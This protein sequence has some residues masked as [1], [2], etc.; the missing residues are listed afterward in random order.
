[1]LGIPLPPYRASAVAFLLCGGASALA[2]G[3]RPSP[4]DQPLRFFEGRTE[5]VSTVKVVMKKPYQSRTIGN[6]RILPD[7][8]LALV[9]EVRE[10]GKPLV[11]RHWKIR[12]VGR[13]KFAGTMSDAV[14]PVTVNEAKGTYRFQFKLKGH[15]AVDQW[16]RPLP[17]GKTAQ[18]RMTVRKL[19]MQ[20]ASSQGIIRKI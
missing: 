6:G 1:M 14:G 5:M 8:S 19:G 17:G 2:S 16:V 18:S 4:A 15:L 10:E 11:K 7:G 12:E 9:Q 20:V 13:G 3:E